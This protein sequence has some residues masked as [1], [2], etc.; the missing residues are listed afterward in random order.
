MYIIQD[1]KEDRLKYV[2]SFTTRAAAEAVVRDLEDQ[3]KRDGIYEPDQYVVNRRGICYNDTS[4]TCGH[5]TNCICMLEHP[6]LDCPLV[7]KR[8][9]LAA[10][11]KS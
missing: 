5:C 4:K 2:A 7:K 3:D 10:G 1:K 9:A 6:D 11:G 8:A